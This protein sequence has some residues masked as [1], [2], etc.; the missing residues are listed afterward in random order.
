MKYKTET[1]PDRTHVMAET[2]Y[3]S[4]QVYK[5]TVSGGYNTISYDGGPMY[6]GGKLNWKYCDHVRF[7]PAPPPPGGIVQT[8]S[9]GTGKYFVYPPTAPSGAPP[10]PTDE[11]IGAAFE[12]L[13]NQVDLNCKDSVLIYSGLLQAL[14]L[15]GLALKGVS[16]LNRAARRLRKDL[17]RQPFTTVVRSLISADF[18]NRF[19][20]QPT[21]ADMQKFHHAVDYVCNVLKTARERNDNG[22]TAIE[23]EERSVDEHTESSGQLVTPYLDPTFYAVCDSVVDRSVSVKVKALADIRY[24]IPAISPIQLWATRT[25]IT[26]PL[27]SAWD[28]VPFSFVIDYFFRAGDFIAEA[29]N[30]VASQDALVGEI[31]RIRGAWVMSTSKS[32]CTVK[33]VGSRRKRGSMDGYAI[34][35]SSTAGRVHFTRVPASFAFLESGL[36]APD[37]GLIH[38]DLTRTRLRTL[39]ELFVQ[40]RL[41][42]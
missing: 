29:S 6:S 19:V 22:R 41:R 3:G 34:S 1:Y 23:G 18:V 15:A 32:T 17:R 11:L 13:L 35:G 12:K 37:R 42:R 25:G 21:I 5:T 39:A 2:W 16:M 20:I 4:H 9:I 36:L 26:K 31:M 40:A 30:A 28:L 7:D 10:V 24:N 14:P 27:E 8:G 33:V 38:C